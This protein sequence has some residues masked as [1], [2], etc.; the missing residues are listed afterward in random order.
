VV[1]RVLIRS[2]FVGCRL[3]LAPLVLPRSR[4]PLPLLPAPLLLLPLLFPFLL[5]FTLRRS[6][7]LTF[8]P[9]PLLSLTRRWRSGKPCAIPVSLAR[10]AQRTWPGAASCGHSM[11][12]FLGHFFGNCPGWLNPLHMATCGR[13]GSLVNPAHVV[14]IVS[15]G[16]VSLCILSP[17]CTVGFGLLEDGFS[18]RPDTPLGLRF[19]LLPSFP[20]TRMG[21]GAGVIATMNPK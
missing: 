12:V 16:T 1:I 8:H 13:R 7:G 17:I 9:S 18:N 4:T 21:D 5:F 10:A 15:L 20:A 11:T 19:A 6:L 2:L 3:V 14:L